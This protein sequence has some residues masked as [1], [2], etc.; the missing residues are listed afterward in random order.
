MRLV[1]LLILGIAVVAVSIAMWAIVI[2]AAGIWP[3]IICA[4]LTPILLYAG[5]NY[6]FYGRATPD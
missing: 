2:E 6:L 1:G 3:L 5:A 4:V